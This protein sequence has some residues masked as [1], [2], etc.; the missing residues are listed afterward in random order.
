MALGPA[1]RHCSRPTFKEAIEKGESTFFAED[2]ANDLR[3]EL[4]IFAPD[5]ARHHGRDR[6]RIQSG[7]QRETMLTFGDHV[8]IAA[9]LAKCDHFGRGVP[10]ER[11][12]AAVAHRLPQ[13]VQASDLE[14]EL[15]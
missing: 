14:R 8:S 11:L 6:F 2:A 7:S 5:D 1:L 9:V 4:D 15:R 10:T 12:E 13:T 3:P